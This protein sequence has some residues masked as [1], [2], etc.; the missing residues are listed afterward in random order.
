VP[1]GPS[2]NVWQFDPAANAMLG[3]GRNSQHKFW[4]YRY[5]P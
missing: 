4:L 1:A 5:G 2:G 3:V